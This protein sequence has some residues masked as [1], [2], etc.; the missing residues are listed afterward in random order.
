M[1]ARWSDNEDDEGPWG[2]REG[3]W[4][5]GDDADYMQRRKKASQGKA[6]KKEGGVRTVG[7]SKP[8]HDVITSYNT[9]TRVLPSLL[10]PGESC[11]RLPYTE[12]TE[13]IILC[14][15]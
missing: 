10:L 15:L 2:E 6:Q 11:S 7:R 14:C 12:R 1:F 3:F 4:S 5:D 13:C 9:T 8:R